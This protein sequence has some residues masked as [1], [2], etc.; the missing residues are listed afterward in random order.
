[1]TAEQWA[2]WVS[3]VFGLLNFI[4]GILAYRGRYQA[5]LILKGSLLPGWPGLASLY[6]GVAFMMIGVGPLV[7]GYAPPLLQLAHFFLL[8]PC[9]VVGIISVFWLPSFMIPAWIKETRRRM[10]AGEDQY[11]KDMAPGGV[12]HG[13]LGVAARHQ[14]GGQGGPRV[15]KPDADGRNR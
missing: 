1:M 11:S 13:R 14:N 9:L 15:A 10:R 3:F 6:L 7:L 2:P 12:L 8:F 4:A 5:W